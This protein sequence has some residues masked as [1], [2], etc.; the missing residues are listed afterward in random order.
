[1]SD[2]EKKNLELP[3][4]SESEGQ[5]ALEPVSKVDF[6]SFYKVILLNDD[7][8]PKEFVVMVL[9]KIFSK[10]SNEANQIMLQVH[11]KGSGLAGIYSFEIAETKAFQC[12]QL[13]KQNKYPLKCTVEKVS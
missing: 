7:F 13:A 1:M 3:L 10:S 2:Q 6:P 8:T 12:H 4:E 11:H 5:I 9:E